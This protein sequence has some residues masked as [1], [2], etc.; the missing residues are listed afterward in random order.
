MASASRRT[1]ANTL[2]GRRRPRYRRPARGRCRSGLVY[3]PAGRH[4]IH[5]GAGVRARLEDRAG[6][7][8]RS[9]R[10][11]GAPQPAAGPHH[12]GL[13]R[14]PSRRSVRRAVCGFAAR[15]AG[16]AEGGVSRT[17]LALVRSLEVSGPLFFAGDGAVRY[18]DAIVAAL[19]DRADVQ[20][21]AAALAAEAGRIAA[22]HPERAVTPDAIVPI[23]VRRPDAELARDRARTR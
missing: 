20:A 14:R 22:V 9:D 10:P 21:S 8:A 6:L 18:R 4:R 15:R 17:D 1:R 11:A 16:A 23:Y 3:R 7:R 12:R 19:G 13:G 5:A 2:G